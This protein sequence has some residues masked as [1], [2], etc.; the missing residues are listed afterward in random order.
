MK[1][2]N[3]F[4]KRLGRVS[5]TVYSCLEGLLCA[6]VQTFVV[7]KKYCWRM[8]ERLG[9]QTTLFFLGSSTRNVLVNAGLLASFVWLPYGFSN[10]KWKNY[11]RVDWNFFFWEW[12]SWFS[13]NH[14][15]LYSSTTGEMINVFRL[16]WHFS[17]SFHL[18]LQWDVSY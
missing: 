5:I 9:Q 14:W 3:L 2:K 8:K 4:L 12:I 16:F 1:W 13:C 15:I 6:D 10:E 11:L 18:R 17:P 7:E